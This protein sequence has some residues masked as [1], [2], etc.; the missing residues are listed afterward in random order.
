MVRIGLFGSMTLSVGD[1]APVPVHGRGAR[2]LAYLALGRGRCV[3]RSELLERVWADRGDRMSAGTFNTALWRLRRLLQGASGECGHA[4]LCDAGAA[5]AFDGQM[6]VWLDVAEFERL[7]APGL[8]AG[9]DA[10]TPADIAG[11]EAAVRLYNADLLLDHDDDWILRERERHRRTY[12]NA[13]GRLMELALRRA[14][15]GDA[16]AHG[17]AILDCEP[18]RED[19]HRALMEAYVDAGQRAMA[20]RQFEHCRA[21]L[22]SELAIAPMPDTMALYRQI[23][24]DALPSHA[25][26]ADARCDT[27]TGALHMAR[28]AAGAGIGN[29]A[30]EDVA[31]DEAR[32]Y[33]DTARRLLRNA[34]A[35]LQAGLALLRE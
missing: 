26:V 10:V 1:A 27:A 29:E 18:L 12:L 32:P 25:R 14:A 7:A 33:F 5:V 22:R 34:D 21:R 11:L 20:L 28:V 30:P 4:L 24:A 35:Q 3:S 23:A 8:Q 2:L 17:H 6:R 31:G 16:I 19:M 13:R 15:Y 9:I